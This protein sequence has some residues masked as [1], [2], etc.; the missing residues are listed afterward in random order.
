VRSTSG[1]THHFDTMRIDGFLSLRRF[2]LIDGSVQ[3]GVT[4]FRLLTLYQVADP[5]DA[6]F[7]TPAYRQHT[8]TYAPPPEGVTDGIAFERHVL[9]RRGVRSDPHTQPVGEACVSLVGADGPWLQD[10]TAAAAGCGGVLNSYVCDGDDFAVLL[11]DVQSRAD[12]A[13]VLS[14]LSAVEHGGRR[15]SLQLF[16][17]VFPDLGVLVRDRVVVPPRS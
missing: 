14:A 16:G 10:A 12:G 4:E 6:D 7:S 15:R 5:G 2:E 11:V 17:Q 13:G 9:R 8:A 3:P 1:A